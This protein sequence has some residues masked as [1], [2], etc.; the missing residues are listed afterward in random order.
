[1]GRSSHQ[2]QH[3]DF[4]SNGI[5]TSMKYANY[6]IKNIIIRIPLSFPGPHT[7]FP[8][9]LLHKHTYEWN[10]DKHTWNRIH[11]R[12]LVEHNMD[13]HTITVQNK[14]AYSS[15]EQIQRYPAHGWLGTPN[16]IQQP[17]HIY[18]RLYIVCAWC[19]FYAHQPCIMLC[20]AQDVWQLHNISGCV[21]ECAL[22]DR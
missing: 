13:K 8:I 16:S 7:W 14:H 12:I 11:K 19:S 15:F 20:N 9:A 18:H 17:K 1:M 5:G 22:P 4:N 3:A 6:N 10:S 21:R 2:Q